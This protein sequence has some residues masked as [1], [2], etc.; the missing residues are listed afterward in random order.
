MK[1]LPVP[2]LADTVTRL[3]KTVAPF[4]NDEEKKEIE[5]TTPLSR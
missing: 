4:A 3:L 1:R 5:G 2:Q